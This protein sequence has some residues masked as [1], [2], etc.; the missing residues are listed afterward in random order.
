MTAEVRATETP[1]EPNP[2]D[3]DLERRVAAYRALRAQGAVVPFPGVEGVLGAVSYD[4]VDLGLRSVDHFGGS[5]GQDDLPD[6]DKNIAAMVE[7]RHG[8]VRRIINSVVAFHKSQQIEPYLQDL[9]KRLVDGMLAEALTAGARGVDV[10]EHLAGPIPP[11]AMARLLGFPEEDSHLYYQ[12][13]QEGGRRFQEAAARGTTLAAADANPEQARYVDEK[14]E[15]RLALPREEWPEDALTRFLVTEVDGERLEPRNIRAQIM[16]M[17]GAGS[18]TT[19]NLIGSLLYRLG[20][21]PDAYAALRADPELI[22]VAIE[23]SLRADAPAQF[24]VRTCR[25][26]MDLAGTPIAEGQRVFMCIGS[27]NHDEAK[28]DDPDTFRL[29][30]P[31]REHLS[32]G[33][34]PHICPGA[35]LA[36]LEV[37]T[38]MHEFTR[39][40]ASYHLVDPD[41]Y[42]AVPTGMLQG[43]RTL[44]IVIDEVVPGA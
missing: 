19:K 16:F 41:R 20:R 39:R 42:D 14:I 43:Q 30:R 15:A 23:E 18:E 33:S 6:I 34:G 21:D 26:P 17:I 4:A 28:F 12:W 1:E 13:V 7:P 5:A 3:S 37:R 32:F 40:V 10:M 29:D 38:L 9:V 22:D 27:G 44:V 35:A 24:M 31:T 25:K 36:R 8:K 11:A 2:L